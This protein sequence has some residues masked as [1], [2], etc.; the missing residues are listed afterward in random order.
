LNIKIIPF[1]F[2][3]RINTDVGNNCMLAGDYRD[4]YGVDW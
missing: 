3:K 2:V 1:V 4:Q